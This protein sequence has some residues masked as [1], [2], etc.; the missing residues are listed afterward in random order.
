[1]HLN[2]T[3][4]N[5][6]DPPY[7]LFRHY[8][9]KMGKE[10]FALL[11]SND[12]FPRNHFSKHLHC[13]LNLSVSNSDP[14]PGP[15]NR[16]VLKKQMKERGFFAY[17]SDFIEL[18]FPFKYLENDIIDIVGSSNGI[19]CLLDATLSSTD[20]DI[21]PILWNPS[22]RKAMY[23]PRPTVK[24]PF[25][26]LPME[27]VGLGYDP[28]TDDYKLQSE[29]V[30]VNGSVHWLAETEKNIRFDSDDDDTFRN[31][32]F[33]FHIGDEIFH[34]MAVPKCVE[35]VYDLNMNLAV[36]GGSLALIP[37]N[38]RNLGVEQYSVWV[39]K[40]YGVAESWTKI[41]DIDVGEGLGRVVGF[42]NNG[43]ALVTKDGK[44]LFYNPSSRR[45]LNPHIYAQPASLYL[46]TY[47][48]SLVLL[49]VEYGALGRQEDS[50][51]AISHI[52]LLC[53]QVGVSFKK[54]GKGNYLLR[55]DIL[56][57][58]V[59]PLLTPIAATHANCRYINNHC[60]YINDM[61]VAFASR[62][63]Y[64]DRRCFRLAAALIVDGFASRRSCFHLAI[65]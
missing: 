11:S 18:H 41:F 17:P 56:A 42:T 62:H 21:V 15:P 57:T 58:A 44:L 28:I 25:S 4:S 45:T 23:L 7:L 39:M 19:V 55:T 14:N 24:F 29:S 16:L 6:K 27:H 20:Y 10:H 37:W 43:E 3:L 64:C 12:P 9:E 60:R 34:E 46:D 59:P 65:L 31:G 50:S 38:R 30:F 1:M 47:M 40:E 48:D 5:T 26:Y 22:I 52:S 32:I 61:I 2:R 54:A 35:L 49:N 13:R 53:F 36:L 33:T 63:R 51:S 8:D